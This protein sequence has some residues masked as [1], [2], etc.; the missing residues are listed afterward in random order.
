MLERGLRRHCH[1]CVCAVGGVCGDGVPEALLEDFENLKRRK[2]ESVVVEFPRDG[3]GLFPLWS[4]V[5][6]RSAILERKVRE[7]PDDVQG[8]SEVALR[9]GLAVVAG[10]SVSAAVVVERAPA[11]PVYEE[12]RR[13][14]LR[15]RQDDAQDHLLVHELFQSIRQLLQPRL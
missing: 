3:L 4:P 13:D 14:P 10:D 6:A 15:R 1:H 2:E 8:V 9:D 12:R 5:A 7:T 11:E